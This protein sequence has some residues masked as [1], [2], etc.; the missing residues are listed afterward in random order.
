MTKH[1]M[2]PKL[3]EMQP[4]YNETMEVERYVV[5]GTKAEKTFFRAVKEGQ[6]DF[7]VNKKAY[8]LNN[9]VQKA[10]DVGRFSHTEEACNY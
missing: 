10:A 2:I 6:K 3:T 9:Q 8:D 1:T 5:P 7:Y 4:V